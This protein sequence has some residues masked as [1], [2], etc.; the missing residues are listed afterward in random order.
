M[1]EPYQMV[2]NSRVPQHLGKKEYLK[3]FIFAVNPDNVWGFKLLRSKG[4]S[5]V[6]MGALGESARPCTILCNKPSFSCFLLATRVWRFKLLHN[7]E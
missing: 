3:L 5:L 2:M 6:E 1:P 7:I 4:L